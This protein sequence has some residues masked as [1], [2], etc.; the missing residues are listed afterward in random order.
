MGHVEPTSPGPKSQ[1]LSLSKEPFNFSLL[2]VGTPITPSPEGT[3]LASSYL[4]P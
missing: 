4:P 1:A 3:H 2:P